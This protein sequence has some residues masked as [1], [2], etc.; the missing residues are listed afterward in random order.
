MNYF[1]CI[2]W[3]RSIQSRYWYCCSHFCTQWAWNIKIINRGQY[4]SSY[5]IYNCPIFFPWETPSVLLTVEYYGLCIYHRF[6]LGLLF[7]SI[8]EY[9]MKSI[10][11]TRCIFDLI[12][13]YDNMC[14]AV[15]NV[16]MF[17]TW[18]GI[19]GETWA[20]YVSWIRTLVD[21]LYI[22]LINQKSC[23]E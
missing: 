2:R 20:A 14:N 4:S 7:I 22:I 13:E 11:V 12:Y 21:E 16:M 23:H 10:F 6:T 17:K 19:F 1:E 9:N 15:R 5:N 18:N 3:W 8:T